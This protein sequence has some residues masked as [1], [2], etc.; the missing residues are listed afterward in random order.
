MGNVMQEAVGYREMNIPF[1]G[2]SI[3]FTAAATAGFSPSLLP[4]RILWFCLIAFLHSILKKV[5]RM[6]EQLERIAELALQLENFR[7]GVEMFG[8]QKCHW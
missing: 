4:E 6:L 3:R 1:Q 5:R 7:V 2:T 8:K